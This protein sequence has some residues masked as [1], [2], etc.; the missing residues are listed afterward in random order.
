MC[1]R[2]S[3]APLSALFDKIKAGQIAVAFG[4]TKRTLSHAIQSYD[5]GKLRSTC[6]LSPTLNTSLT[7]H[8]SRFKRC[9]RVLSVTF[10][11]PISIRCNEEVETPSLRAKACKLIGP[12]FSRRT[13]PSRIAKDAAMPIVCRDGFP[14]CE[15]F[16]LTPFPDRN[17]R[18]TIKLWHGSK[19]G[20][21]LEAP[22]HRSHLTAARR[23]RFMTGKANILVV[24]DDTP[25]AMIMVSLLTRAGCDVDA[26]W[27]AQTG[28][29]MARA[30]NFDLITLEVDLPGL[31]GFEVCRR[32][33]ENPRSSDTPI[34][35]VSWRDSLE[36]QQR[37]LE[38]G[39][40]DY[41]TKPF[42][43][44]DFV[45][46]IFSHTEQASGVCRRLNKSLRFRR[47]H[48]RPAF[49]T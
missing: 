28:M 33:K 1:C 12:R 31:S 47:K 26:A 43:A 19:R 16:C 20:Q 15:K 6:H 17:I 32:L 35:F 46:R 39:A 38:L 14:T 49:L 30:G 22:K 5:S 36:N 8:L 34:V 42:D 48:Y 10:C 7:L 18:L 13:R 25:L 40:A 24:E 23:E 11:S 2:D 29:E 21:Q 41:I 37:G 45:S 9:S 4:G 3:A 27:N 44:L